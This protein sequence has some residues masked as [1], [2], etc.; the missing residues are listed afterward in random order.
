VPFSAFST[1][2]WTYGSPKLERYNGVSAMEIQ[3]QAAPGKSTGQAMTAMEGLAKKLP[4]GI[5]YSWT[6][7]SFQEIQS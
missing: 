6:G 3:G 1:G 2:H 5:G 4:V 7:L